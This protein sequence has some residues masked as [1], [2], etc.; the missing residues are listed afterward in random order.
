[1]WRCHAALHTLSPLAPMS[2]KYLA[3]IWLQIELFY[4]RLMLVLREKFILG[5]YICIQLKYPETHYLW[6]PLLETRDGWWHRGS[7]GWSAHMQCS[8]PCHSQIPGTQCHKVPHSLKYI[9]KRQHKSVFKLLS[10]QVWNL[11]L[12][13]WCNTWKFASER[14]WGE[15]WEEK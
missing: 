2:H 1:M 9:S 13:A 3:Q 8:S 10:Q 14:E 4:S 12:N 15:E 5:N 7:G 11:N 6:E